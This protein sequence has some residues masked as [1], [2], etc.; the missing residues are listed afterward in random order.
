MNLFVS[1][2]AWIDGA[3]EEQKCTLPFT[4]AVLLDERLDEANATVYSKRDI[5]PALTVFRMIAYERRAATVYVNH[6]IYYVL[7]NDKSPEYVVGSGL[8]KHNLYLIE[9]TKLLEGI[10]CQT[11]TFTNTTATSI[12]VKKAEPKDAP[13]AAFPYTEMKDFVEDGFSPYSFDTP[14]SKTTAF[15]VPSPKTVGQFV[16][17]AFSAWEHPVSGQAWSVVDETYNLP[18][19]RE[20]VTSE[21]IVQNGLYGNPT[22]YQGKNASLTITD[23]EMYIFLTYRIVIHKTGV[24]SYTDDK[25]I[26]ITYTLTAIQNEHPL[27]RWTVTDEVNRCLELAD[28]IFIQDFVPFTTDITLNA[29]DAAK[30]D[31]VL[32]PEFSMTECTL[33]EQLK[34]IGSF[35]HAE[36]RLTFKESDGELKK[37]LYF[38][39]IAGFEEAVASSDAYTYRECSLS[40]NQYCT[41]IRTTATNLVQSLQYASGTMIDPSRDASGAGTGLTAYRSLRAEES[42]ARVTENNGMFSTQLPIYSLA[43]LKIG[44]LSVDADGTSS[45]GTPL[46]SWWL[47]PTSVKDYVFEETEY[48][49]NLSN[50][51]GAYPYSKSYALYYTIGNKGIRGMFYRAPTQLGS[52]LPDAIVGKYTVTNILAA[53]TTERTA[54][55]IE[56]Y[57]QKN[58][59]CL[60]AQVTYKPIYSALLSHEKQAYTPNATRFE[61]IYNQGENLIE[62]L[63]F[64]EHVKGVAARLGNVEQ[65]RTYVFYDFSRVP[66]ITQ[67]IDGLSISAVSTEIHASFIRCTVALTK[68]YNR[69]SEYVGVNSLKRVYEVSERNTYNRSILLK[70]YITVGQAPISTRV[71]HKYFTL[72]MTALIELFKGTVPRNASITTCL[73]TGYAKAKKGHAPRALSTTRLPVV[74]SA[75]GN[76]MLFSFA[77]K[78]NYS[79]GDTARFLR[80]DTDMAG[81]MTGMWLD[82]CSYTDYFGRMYSMTFAL[83]ADASAPAGLLNNTIPPLDMPYVPSDQSRHLQQMSTAVSSTIGETRYLVRKDSREHLS[84]NVEVEFKSTSDSLI[85]GSALAYLNSL[86]STERVGAPLLYILKKP[87]GDLGITKLSRVLKDIPQGVGET[88]E[89]ITVDIF[90]A[91]TPSLDRFDIVY[92]N[93]PTTGALYVKEFSFK[94]YL[95]SADSCYGWVIAIPP[96]VETETEEDESGTLVSVDTIKGGDVLL[97]SAKK[98]AKGDNLLA[99]CFFYTGNY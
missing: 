69:I 55:Q 34:I 84:F 2:D 38:D 6:T 62:S 64:G 11:L 83:L 60:V 28:P 19:Q 99:D 3:W 52:I 88:V 23:P 58:P 36:P 86:V 91:N 59:G 48:A 45:V 68:D 75:L 14:I 67:T 71:S 12:G 61:Q 13:D 22:T 42:Y 24:E 18:T 93:M 95:L 29:S 79:A 33:R 16:V 43:D 17:D 1:L 4:N 44:I 65:T 56:A 66:K 5:F 98:Y 15:Q 73:A 20:A 96:V 80:F 94:E 90:G 39:P 35:I 32:A 53:C 47:K 70:T 26:R 51:A 57:L 54:S 81:D 41:G 7:A 82:D 63:H 21:V 8:Y 97:M 89:Y 77:Y 46:A 30:Y 92:S 49:A 40:I 9:P 76:A 87:M 72:D 85:I 31:K 50:Y 37:E 27:K 78:D 74:S 25:A 10:P